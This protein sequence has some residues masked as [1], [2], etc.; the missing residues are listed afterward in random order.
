MGY[1]I[2]TMVGVVLLCCVLWCVGAA[3]LPG[4]SVGSNSE[5]STVDRGVE[6]IH[7][8]QH[9]AGIDMLLSVVRANPRSIRGNGML[10]YG[11]LV[12]GDAP[13]AIGYLRTAAT[14]SQHADPVIMSNF[15][16]ALHLSG[17]N[18]EA[19]T[20]CDRHK[21]VPYDQSQNN[22]YANCGNIMLAAGKA[23][24]AVDFF[25]QLVNSDPD[26]VS[27][28][29]KLIESSYIAGIKGEEIMSWI[30][31]FSE[32]HPTDTSLLIK[33]AHHVLVD[34]L[35]QE[36]IVL[37]RKALKIDP[38][39][40]KA[41]TGLASL[42]LHEGIVHEALALYE[43]LLPFPT[44][45]APVRNNYG[46]LLNIK[47]RGDEA[48]GWFEECLAI[49]PTFRMAVENLA[50]MFVKDGIP[51]ESAHYLRQ[52]QRESPT[53]LLYDLQI[54]TLLPIASSSFDEM[55]QYR[56][57]IADNMRALI[58]AW[59]HLDPLRKENLVNE[60]EPRGFYLTY[61]GLNDRPLLEQQ[62]AAYPQ[63]IKDIHW[64]PL[65]PP[66]DAADRVKDELRSRKA[67]IG[68]ISSFFYIAEP[69]GLLLD[70]I[71]KHLPSEHFEVHCLVVVNNASIPLAPSVSEAA[72]FIW[73]VPRDISQAKQALSKVQLDILVFA[74]TWG[75][76]QTHFLA[77]ARFAPYQVTRLFASVMCSVIHTNEFLCCAADGVLG[78]SDDKCFSEH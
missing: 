47:N 17:Q 28:W 51:F 5:D 21:A 3:G 53:P 42:Y 72:D 66:I 75:E 36:A 34:K 30:N 37:Y 40:Y 14:Q 10:G 76:R 20:L 61:H 32:M 35:F 29:E 55:L 31:S 7:Q 50:V 56:I 13:K 44:D 68:F 58:S 1:H 4:L 59:N 45:D 41:K 23:D 24:S 43:S 8:Q 25:L 71:M 19:T 78:K 74:D 16:S 77:Q 54:A 48:R 65:P 62:V 33:Y 6:L 22:L 46:M 15:I 26:V 2:A 27:Y 67:K 60:H 52:L 38:N 70:G 12:I 57:T 11:Y 49:D 18:D 39:D 64:S 63:S 73:Q 9:Q 69:H